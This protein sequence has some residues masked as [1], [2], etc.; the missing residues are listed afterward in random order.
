MSSVFLSP[1]CADWPA[2]FDAIRQELRVTLPGDEVRVEHIGSTA[3]PGLAA[4]P[5]IDVLLGAPAL[6]VVEARIPGLLACGYEY[7]QRY[8]L[9]IPGRRY[10]VR[11][12]STLPR[13]HLHAVE[14]GATLWR[15][16]LAFR[17]ALRS[18]SGLAREYEALKIRLARQ[19]PDDKERYASGKAPFI[20]RI[21][22]QRVGD[23]G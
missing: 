11:A 21:L 15:R 1:Y 12:A 18:E 17:D 16:H 19:Y 14:T 10:F 5:V 9:Q 2:C 13:V 20:A 3:V 23:T 22:A 7:R 6:T 8:E 4:K